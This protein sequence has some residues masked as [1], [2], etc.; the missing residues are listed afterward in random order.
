MGL[1]NLFSTIFFMG[2][3]LSYLR[4]MA[5]GMVTGGL[6]MAINIIAKIALDIPY[7][8][9]I[10]AMILVLIGGHGFNLAINALGAFVHTLRLQYVEFFPKFI[11]GGGRAFQPLSKQYRHIYIAKR[12]Q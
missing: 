9:G 5:L 1:Y 10:V 7:G 4:L 8:L 12:A 6:A 2:D 11:V 3:V